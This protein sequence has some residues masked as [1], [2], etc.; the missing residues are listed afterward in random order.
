MARQFKL[1]DGKK[2]IDEMVMDAKIEMDKTKD[3][4]FQ[5]SEARNTLKKCLV[6]PPATQNT[7]PQQ[8]Q[9]KFSKDDLM[10]KLRLEKVHEH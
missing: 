1:A 7:H 5:T 3:S 10:K 8:S 4:T 6:L 9:T 2:T